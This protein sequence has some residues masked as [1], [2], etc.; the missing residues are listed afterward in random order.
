VRSL[1]S[2]ALFAILA[3]PGIAQLDSN[4]ITVSASRQYYVAPDQVS[5][6]VCVDTGPDV[7]LD[8]VLTALQP[9]SISAANFL[10]V[11]A[12]GTGIGASCSLGVGPVN[13]LEWSFAIDEP[14]ASM[15]DTLRLLAGLQTTFALQKSSFTLTF[16]PQGVK[17]SPSQP[18]KMQD[19]I[20][21][22]HAQALLLADAAG[23]GVGPVVSLS[24]VSPSQPTISYNIAA[25]AVGISFGIRQLINI[26]QVPQCVA[27]V[28]F[29]LLPRT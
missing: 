21:D 29:R 25:F 5:I 7:T 9:A 23:F 24:N 6:G 13:A 17:A 26:A 18:C 16:G 20:A 11:Y 28:K 10:D 14:F 8:Q 2:V 3:S 12:T 22:A 27:V 15:K 1:F 19:L 4:T